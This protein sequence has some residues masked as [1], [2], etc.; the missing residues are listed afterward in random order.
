MTINKVKHDGALTHIEY[1]DEINGTIEEHVLKSYDKPLPEFIEALQ[2]LAP[3]IELICELPEGYSN[4][5]TIRGVSF[6]HA[7]PHETMGASITGLKSLGTSNSPLVI[8]TPHL[9]SEDYNGNEYNTMLLPGSA[10]LNLH[11][12]IS[13][14]ERFVRGERLIV[15]EP[16]LS[17]YQNNV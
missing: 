16:Q 1:E 15:E 2:S 7:G 6:S 14:A 11:W 5:I 9:P 4:S 3:A 12:L 8:N 13:E 10:V 17:L